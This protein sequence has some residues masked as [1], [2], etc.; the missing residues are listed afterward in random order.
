[1]TPA[2]KAEISSVL[3]VVIAGAGKRLSIH[4]SIEVEADECSGRG[5]K[6]MVEPDHGGIL[7]DHLPAI[8]GEFID[9]GITGRSLTLRI[10]IENWEKGWGIRGNLGSERSAGNVAQ[11]WKTPVL[12]VAFVGDKEKSLIPDDRSAEGSPELI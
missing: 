6:T 1:V 5:G 12:P 4:R 8:A 2:V 7:K 9:V 11:E 10:S 3:G